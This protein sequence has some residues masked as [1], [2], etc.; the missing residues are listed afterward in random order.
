MTRLVLAF[1]GALFF[2]SLGAFFLFVPPLLIAFAALLVTCLTLV[3]CLG[4][5]L[6]LQPVPPSDGIDR[7]N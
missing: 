3:F 1:V 6:E 2:G 5:H 7:K 4:I